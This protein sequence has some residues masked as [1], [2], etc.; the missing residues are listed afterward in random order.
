M[1][2]YLI[3]MDIIFAYTSKIY[4]NSALCEETTSKL[5][6]LYLLILYIKD[7]NHWVLI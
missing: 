5:H 6:E 3:F 1:C 2:K 4:I 7:I